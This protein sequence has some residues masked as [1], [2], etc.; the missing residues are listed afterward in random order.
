MTIKVRPHRATYRA[1]RPPLA[2]HALGGVAT[3]AQPATVVMAVVAVIH[4]QRLHL[5]RRTAHLARRQGLELDLLLRRPDD[6]PKPTV[7]VSPV[8]VPPVGRIFLA[9][10]P[11]VVDLIAL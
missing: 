7:R 4:V 5:T 2:Q 8:R 3:G 9:P 11:L 6:A 1:R 10:A